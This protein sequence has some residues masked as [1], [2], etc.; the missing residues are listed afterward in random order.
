[1]KIS[2][3]VDT[4]SLVCQS[5]AVAVIVYRHP[6]CGPVQGGLSAL[7]SH[8]R[9]ETLQTAVRVDLVEVEGA[10]LALVT[11]PALNILQTLTPAR[12]WT[13]G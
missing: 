4:L 12:G 1:M 11:V 3:F 7:I 6:Q 9:T 13:V 8:S 5:Q 10:G 2:S